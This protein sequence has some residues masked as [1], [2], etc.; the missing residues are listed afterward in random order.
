MY[1]KLF[2]IALFLVMLV[3][4]TCVVANENV[5]TDNNAIANVE[6]LEVQS[7]PIDDMNEDL[8]TDNDEDAAVTASNNGKLNPNLNSEVKTND[9]YV[10][11]TS[12]VE[13]N[14]TGKVSIEI[15]KLN[16]GEKITDSEKIENG[17]A[18]WSEFYAFEK[19]D[20]LANMTYSGDSN[21]KSASVQKV[22]EI[23]KSMTEFNVL[24]TTSE[25]VVKVA[26]IVNTNATGTVTFRIKT[27]E[28][29]NFTE[30]GN[31]VLEN[32]FVVWADQISFKKGDYV[33]FS[34][35]NGDENYFKAGNTQLFTI[36][37][38]K[39][40]INVE[41]I[42]NGGFVKVNTTLNEN[43]TGNATIYI[44]NAEED[45]Y[46]FYATQE[47]ENG[48]ALWDEN[49][50]FEKGDYS[51]KLEYSGDD[52]FFGTSDIQEFSIEKNMVEL[53][54]EITTNKSFVTITANVTENATGNVTISIKTAEEENFTEYATIELENGAVIWSNTEPFDKGTYVAYIRYNG[55]ENY[56]DAE[57]THNFTIKNQIENFD[58]NIA[59]NKYLIV[60]NATLPEDATG[61]VTFNIRE[62]DEENYTELATIQ[63]EN[64][65]AAWSDFVIF[66]KGEYEAYT[67][68]TGDENYY[69]AENTQNF[70]IEKQ[71]ADMLTYSTVN[72]T[73]ATITAILP[74]NATGI[75]TLANNRTGETKNVTLNGTSVEFSEDLAEG[76]NIFEVIYSGDDYYF[77]AENTLSIPVQIETSLST[78]SPVNVTYLNTVKKVVKLLVMNKTGNPLSS[79]ENVTITV[80]NQTYI[81]ILENGSVTIPIVASYAKKFIPG[82]YIANVTFEGND[83]LKNAS[84]TFKLVVKK[85]TPKMTAK[86]KTFKVSTKTKKYTITM[87]NHKNSL[88][89]NAKVTLKVNGK[90]FKAT[91][92]EKGQATFKI[93]NL[94]KKAIFYAVVKYASSKYYNSVS[95]KVKITV[96]K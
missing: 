40:D 88:M 96:K 26:A 19:G 12:T 67:T 70:T 68:Y 52:N 48:N 30:Y 53:Q 66:T 50:T 60:L 46:T 54:T 20:Y 11:I 93:T 36:K 86:A 77:G 51:L 81:G 78:K 83:Y 49:I 23:T 72:G 61:N 62:S 35:Y 27:A 94:N 71:F 7:T 10:T 2:C 56:Y 15:K 14:A 24:I 55:D 33:L 58:V 21:Y 87:K 39:P 63:V 65:T 47:L 42:K 22:F 85:G 29:E 1:K 37:K 31:E 4:M 91:T 90:T 17:T 3:G 16:G 45:V 5:S 18:I 32:G 41:V 8:S 43:A 57:N 73:T 38:D 64:G 75:V 59:V 28:E 74:E 34:E 82:T 76:F 69:N 44:K 9:A 80:N 92:N 13:K 6:D 25:D 95:K 84:T 79:G 89:K